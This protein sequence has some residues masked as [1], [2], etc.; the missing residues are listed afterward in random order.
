[1]IGSRGL[2]VEYP[3][4]KCVFKWKVVFSVAWG[5]G[6]GNN[7]WGKGGGRRD[8]VFCLSK[9]II[10]EASSAWRYKILNFHWN[11]LPHTL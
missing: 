10:L 2:A 9:N 4:S 6:G 8:G 7:A 5:K 3:A 1:M 11:H